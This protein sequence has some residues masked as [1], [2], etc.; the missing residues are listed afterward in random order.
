MVQDHFSGLGSW[1]MSH[2]HFLKGRSSVPRNKTLTEFIKQNETLRKKKKKLFLKRQ[3]SY[4]TYNSINK[5]S[6]TK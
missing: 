2:T 3:S 6:V 5:N 1:Q 4:T